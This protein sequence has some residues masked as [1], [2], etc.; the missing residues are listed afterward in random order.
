MIY[1]DIHQGCLPYPDTRG[2]NW[3]N[4]KVNY[5]KLINLPPCGY[6]L[7]LNFVDFGRLEQP[8][9]CPLNQPHGPSWLLG[10]CLTDTK[11]NGFYTVGKPYL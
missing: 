10:A 11:G 4:K 3:A 1:N 5:G 9:T 8:W 7:P 6:H 2:V